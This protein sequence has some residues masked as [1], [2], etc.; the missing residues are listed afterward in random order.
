MFSE[1]EEAMEKFILELEVRT[2]RHLEK[3]ESSRE[4]EMISAEVEDAIEKR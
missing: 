1:T 3:I 4:G 2:E